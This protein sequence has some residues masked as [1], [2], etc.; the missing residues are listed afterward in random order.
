MSTC[1]HP[2]QNDKRHK[3]LCVWIF[4]DHRPGHL[5]QLKGLVDRL[6]AH[7]LINA[8]WL[9]V[10]TYG[11]KF[12]QIL[13]RSQAL[14]DLALKDLPPPDIILGAGHRTH[15]SVLLAGFVFKAFTVL[16]M[17]PSLPLSWFDAVICPWHD[18]IK[19]RPHVLATFGPI[20]KITPPQANSLSKERH[21][22]LI[23]IGGPSKHF[24]FES[25]LVIQQV[26]QLC[27]ENP[28]IQW[29]LSNSP[30]TPDDFFDLLSAQK[31][32]NLQLH[33][34]QDAALPKLETLLCEAAMVWLSPD[35]MSMI[36]EALTAGAKVGLFDAETTSKHKKG[37]IALEIQHL[38]DSQRV[39]DFCARSSMLTRTEAPDFFWEAERA[40]LWLLERCAI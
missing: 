5:S 19:D 22:H 27:N 11:I 8:H 10:A 14:N 16:L 13:Y 17:K 35:S 6:E 37:R 38:I 12:S 30:R 28:A 29:T 33:D 36:Y 39:L 4:H 9:D 15:T 7:A 40:A 32:A 3:V 21:R 23:L 24:R 20:N 31:P 26:V 2:S 25:T 1:N 34:F 18:Q